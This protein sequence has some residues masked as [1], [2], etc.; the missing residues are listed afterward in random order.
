[1]YGY[2]FAVQ[3]KVSTTWDKKIIIIKVSRSNAKVFIL[4]RRSYY[5][6]TDF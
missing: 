6:K 3:T 4:K 5:K 1:M 2:T